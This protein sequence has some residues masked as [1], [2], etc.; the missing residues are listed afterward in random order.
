MAA[1]SSRTDDRLYGFSKQEEDKGRRND[2]EAIEHTGNELRVTKREFDDGEEE[3]EEDIY[4]DLLEFNKSTELQRTECASGNANMNADGSD[5]I[6][7]QNANEELRSQLEAL[8]QELALAKSEREILVKN[9]S[10]IYKVE[11]ALFLIAL[12]LK[13]ITRSL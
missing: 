11:L 10:C 6:Q 12:T 8:K 2:D 9:M 1:A 5:V 3:I 13:L 4:G 7:L